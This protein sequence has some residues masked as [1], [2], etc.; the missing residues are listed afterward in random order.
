MTITADAT[1]EQ[2][3]KVCGQYRVSGLPVVDTD[4]KLI[5]IV[6]NRDLRFTPVKEWATTRS[7]RS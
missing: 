4:H 3:D 6:T 7:T 5:G 2:L 1:L